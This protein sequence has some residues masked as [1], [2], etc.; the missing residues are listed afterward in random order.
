MSLKEARMTSLPDKLYEG[1]ELKGGNKGKKESKLGRVLKGK[2][3][4]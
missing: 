3:S 1:K 2:K 4:K